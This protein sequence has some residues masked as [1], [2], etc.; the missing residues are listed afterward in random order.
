MSKG[1]KNKRKGVLAWIPRPLE[2]HGHK[3]K[4]TG[5]LARATGGRL[6]GGCGDCGG[7]GGCGGGGCCMCIL[8]IIILMTGGFFGFMT[9]F[10]TD[11]T[12]PPDIPDATAYYQMHITIREVGEMV[13]AHEALIYDVPFEV[14]IYAVSGGVP[15]YDIE[16]FD[17]SDIVAGESAYDYRDYNLLYVELINEEFEFYGA[18]YVNSGTLS[19]I[20]IIHLDEE[21]FMASISWLMDGAGMRF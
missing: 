15:D 6:G 2:P 21:V 14:V 10:D 20:A 8:V 7:C 11:D 13:L 16:G 1:K 5:F 9:G 17:M 4:S 19:T 12:P 18:G 3:R